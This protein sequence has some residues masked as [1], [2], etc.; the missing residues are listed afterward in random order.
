MVTA[1][2]RRKPI[3]VIKVERH[4]PKTI[5]VLVIAIIALIV[6]RSSIWWQPGSC[7][8][9]SGLGTKTEEGIAAYSI[10][11]REDRTGDGALIEQY[12]ALSG[13]GFRAKAGA[14]SP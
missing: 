1:R 8:R 10:D 14:R 4:D 9:Q 11:C 6:L 3:Q 13:A 2:N 7:P 12:P 5:T